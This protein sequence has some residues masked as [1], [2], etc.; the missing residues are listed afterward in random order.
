MF[1]FGDQQYMFTLHVVNYIT[2]MCL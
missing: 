2:F 1:S